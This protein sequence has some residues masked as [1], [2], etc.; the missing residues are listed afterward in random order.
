[1][2]PRRLMRGFKMRFSHARRGLTRNGS[3]NLAVRFEV[4]SFI[5][6]PPRSAVA[7][8]DRSRWARDRAGMPSGYLPR[9]F[10]KLDLPANPE[11]WRG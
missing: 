8:T 11:D 3:M 9:R 7:K 2:R 10:P 6:R 4:S 1:M 5:C